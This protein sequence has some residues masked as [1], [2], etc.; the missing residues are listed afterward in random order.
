MAI[1]LLNG[2]V[3]GTG[4][5]VHGMGMDRVLVRDG[6]RLNYTYEKLQ[7]ERITK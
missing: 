6:F 2:K 3:D 7:E 4:E 5:G 1:D